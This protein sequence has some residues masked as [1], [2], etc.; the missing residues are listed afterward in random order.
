ML[1]YV[2]SK[3]GKPLMPCNPQKARRLLKEQKAKVVKR[4]PFTIQLLYGS[5]GYKQ[6]VILGVDA[7]SKTIGVSASTENKELFSAEVELRTD[8]VDLLSTRR[9]LRRSRRNRKTRYGQ[10]RFLNRRKPEGWVAPSVQNKIDTHIKVVKLVHAIL[11]ITRVVVEV[12]QFDVQKIKNP[13]I[14]GEDYQQGEQLGFYNVR[15]YVLFRDK[16]TCQHCNGK[17]R[18]PILNVHH[19]ES[20]KTGG[21][22]PDNLITLCE[23]CHKRYHK[24]G[25][26]LK[27]K[28]NS[29]FRDAAFMGIMRWAS[30]NKLKEQYSNV[31]LTFGYITKNV[32]IKHNLE[33]SHRILS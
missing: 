22:S 27:V 6:D 17:S 13:D 26:E 23:T 11:P 30:Y 3:H 14:L 10:S 25:I 7:K 8:I 5:S 28:R 1:V 18:D 24:G 4:T 20:R 15:E 29:S 19:I 32:R 31:H 12:A 33:K 2:I 21:N 9:T 16:H